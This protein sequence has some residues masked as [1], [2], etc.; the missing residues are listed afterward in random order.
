MDEWMKRSFYK[1]MKNKK[2]HTHAHTHKINSS[3]MNIEI[4]AQ[5][6]YATNG[7]MYILLYIT[8]VVSIPLSDI[9]LIFFL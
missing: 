6:E 4:P 2:E 8:T 1:Q 3:K 5:N 7:N 9:I